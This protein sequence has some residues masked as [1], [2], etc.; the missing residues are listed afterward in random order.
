MKA[1]LGGLVAVLALAWAAAWS[2]A[3]A[4]TAHPWWIAYQQLL[5]LS[6]LLAIGLLSLATFLA[7]RPAWLETPLGGMD[8]IYRT[9]K[10][11]G[12]LGGVFA[13]LH[14][15]IEMSDD[16][17]KSSIGRAGR[18]PKEKFG[19]ILD[20]LRHLAGDLGE[21]GFYLL[22]VL[23]AITLWQRFPYRNWRF[24]HR[25]MPVLYLLL[26]F[27]S[28]LL[29]PATYWTQPSGWLLGL[30]VALGSY[31]AL[32]SLLGNVGRGRSVRGRI[33]E[34]ETLADDVL[35][36]R[37]RLDAGWRGHRPGQFALVTFDRA[38]GAHPFTIADADR[39]DACVEF[40][41]KALGDYTRRLPAT[42]AVGSPV[43][44][45]GP[46]GRFELARRRADVRQLW[47]AGGIGVTPFLAWLAALQETPAVAQAELHYCTRDRERDPFVARLQALCAGLPGVRLRVHGAAQGER[48]DAD[49]LLAG[50]GGPAEVWFCG[51]AGLAGA[52][53]DGLGRQ[54]RRF[55]QEAFRMR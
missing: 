48:L 29:A 51:P 41:I 55:H 22:V 13:I 17:L 23:V 52:L 42:L 39:G 18:V 19:N 5:Y 11:A 50:R 15:L 32:R 30:F 37:C 9:H 44:V 7:A 2:L 54:V 26:A 53:R 40:C 21:W 34:L 3:P 4:S 27:H 16:L 38:E 31:G 24:L 8:R 33:V 20:S 25:A 28:V 45:E 14:W 12:I 10:W 46:Y 35:R 43:V 1:L 49:A 6:G 47:V 36:V